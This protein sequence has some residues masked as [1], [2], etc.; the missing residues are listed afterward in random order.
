MTP[1]MEY[2]FLLSEVPAKQRRSGK[3]AK[4]PPASLFMETI[5]EHYGY[6]E[7]KAREAMKL[8]SV[9]D[10]MIIEQKQ[11]KEDSWTFSGATGSR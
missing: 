3:W 4:R 2:Q 8:L 9:E 5:R 7:Q 10:M 1:K 6:N 11:K